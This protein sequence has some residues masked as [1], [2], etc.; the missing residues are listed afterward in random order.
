MDRV[1]RAPMVR[2]VAE[3][4][5]T[6]YGEAVGRSPVRGGLA[7]G[8]PGGVGSSLT[9]AASTSCLVTRPSM[10]DPVKEPRSISWAAA[11]REAMGEKKRR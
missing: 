1:K 10:P 6:A 9:I 2:R 5:T 4:S 8:P 7:G 3:S 11:K